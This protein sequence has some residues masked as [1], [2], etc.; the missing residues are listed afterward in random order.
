MHHYISC[1][2]TDKDTNV[3]EIVRVDQSC[4][5]ITRIIEYDSIKSKITICFISMKND[6]S[7]VKD[8]RKTVDRVSFRDWWSKRDR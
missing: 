6:L 3:E 2:T 8:K 5:K 4:L 7:N 1:T